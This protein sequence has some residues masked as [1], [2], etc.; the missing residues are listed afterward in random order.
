M[1]GSTQSTKHI[2]TH[3]GHS[4]CSWLLQSCADLLGTLLPLG[5]CCLGH[6][7]TMSGSLR[8]IIYIGRFHCFKV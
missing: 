2:H 1:P 6:S 4:A 5:F 7:F 3:T 8:N